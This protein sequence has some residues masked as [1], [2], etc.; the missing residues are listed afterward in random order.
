[1]S[2][3]LLPAIYQKEMKNIAYFSL[4]GNVAT[5]AAI[6]CIFGIEIHTLSSTNAFQENIHTMKFFDWKAIPFYFGMTMCLFEGNGMILNL[7]AEV[8][9]PQKFPLQFGIVLTT[10]TFIAIVVGSLSYFTY[11]NSIESIILYNLPHHEVIS[12]VTKF[13]YVLTIMGI[14][15]LLLFPVYKVI[16]SY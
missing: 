14:Y 15:V 1:M 2:I 3:F 5:A 13:L 4:I 7:Y 9:K 16:E 10:I 6:L 12:V 8:D 11:G